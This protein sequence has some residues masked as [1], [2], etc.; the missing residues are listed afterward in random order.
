M[1]MKIKLHT[2]VILLL[3]LI[4]LIIPTYPVIYA[5]SNDSATILKELGMLS[6]IKDS[7]LSTRLN[8]LV[9]LTMMLKAL[10]YTD[11]DAKKVSDNTIYKDLRD[12]FAWG[13]GWV[14]IGVEKSITTGTSQNTFNPGDILTKKEFIVYTLRLLG[15]GVEESY[16]ECDKLAIEAE[17]ID[18]KSELLDGYFTKGDAAEIIYTALSAKLKNKNNITLIEQMI[19]DGIVMKEVAVKYEIKGVN[20]LLLDVV[21]PI[22]NTYLEITLVEPID[23]VDTSDLAIVDNDGNEIELVSTNLYNKGRTIILETETQEEGVMHT[24]TINHKSYE[25]ESL[26][27]EDTKPRLIDIEVVNNTTVRLIFDEAMSERALDDDYYSINSLTVKSAHYELVKI[28]IDDEEV[29]EE[30]DYNEE[31][32]V[33]D[34]E[35]EFQLVMTNIILTTSSQ[36]KNKDYH[37]VVEKLTDLSGNRINTSYDDEY[38]SGV[39][40]DTV[41]PRLEDATAISQTKIELV[42]SEDLNES[43]AEKI[44]NYEIEDLTIKKATLDEEDP[45]IVYLLTSDQKEDHRYKVEVTNIEDLQGKV[46]DP[47]Y[48]TESFYGYERDKASPKLIDVNSISNTKVEVTFNE[49]MDEATGL[50]EYAY[51][52]GEE[53]GYALDVQKD[54]DETD[55]TV[56]IVL[57]NPQLDKEY[58]LTIRGL[59]D[60]EGN[61]I[62]EDNCEEQFM[63]TAQD[64]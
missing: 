55:G 57:T 6:N 3:L 14:N 49:P 28:A 37:V 7:E 27:D 21:K 58:T 33:D 42:F 56:W 18:S 40:T 44:E 53:L 63:G 15:Y 45:T 52:F 16:K 64:E 5:A 24:L 22:A 59:K 8:R 47:S 48:D 36:T 26:L 29:D 12:E 51:Y 2:K 41:R 30:D 35:D 46:I 9:G 10:G 13:K 11:A 61:L 17:L 23:S 32:G 20:D 4:S 54:E 31:E 39:K 1:K 43:I 38:F 50:I 19:E 25:Y 62:D 34:E 60:I